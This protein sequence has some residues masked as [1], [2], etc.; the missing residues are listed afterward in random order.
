MPK[1]PKNPNP[2]P[3]RL[4][5]FWETAALLV[6]A[7]VLLLFFWMFTPYTLVWYAL[8]IL[9]GAVYLFFAVFY[10]P[11]YYVGI[12]FA[13]NEESVMLTTGVFVKRHR[14]QFRKQISSVAVWE[15]PFS[16]A[17]F[18]ATLILYAPGSTLVIPLIDRDAAYAL[19]ERFDHAK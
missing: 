1:K 9:I 8:L 18:L 13:V 4:L 5:W 3:M 7:A 16:S 2:F 17:F 10:L 15:N 6:L 12:G 11:M 19:M 14:R